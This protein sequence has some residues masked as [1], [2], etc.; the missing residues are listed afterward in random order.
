MS[1]DNCTG[2]HIGPVYAEY[3]SSGDINVGVEAGVNAGVGYEA[4]AGAYCEITYNSNE[5]FST[6][7]GTSTSVGIGAESQALGVYSN[8][9]I[10]FDTRDK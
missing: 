3:C 2:I 1:K 7:C 5:G 9:T 8:S 6:G 10:S 4:G